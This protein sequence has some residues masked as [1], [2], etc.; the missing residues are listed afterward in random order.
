MAASSTSGVEYLS[1]FAR[2]HGD[3]SA[4]GRTSGGAAVIVGPSGE[5]ECGEDLLPAG[6]LRL[7]WSIAGDMVAVAN[8]HRLLVAQRDGQQVADIKLENVLKHLSWTLTQCLAIDRQNNI[9]HFDRELP[10]RSLGKVQQ[11]LEGRPTSLAGSDNGFYVTFAD[12][13]GFSWYSGD[14]WR[15]HPSTSDLDLFDARYSASGVY[16]AGMPSDSAPWSLP[17]LLRLR[18]WGPEDL[19]LAERQDFFDQQEVDGDLILLVDRAGSRCLY[20]NKRGVLT[21]PDFHVATFHARTREDI[22]FTAATAAEASTVYR[23]RD[24]ALERLIG[25]GQMH[26][27]AVG[28]ALRKRTLTISAY[29]VVRVVEP[30]VATRRQLQTVLVLH[31][32]PYAAL[33]L[34]YPSVWHEIRGLLA[35]GVRIALMDP[36]GSRGFGLKLGALPLHEWGQKD[37]EQVRSILPMLGPKEQ[38]G[39]LGLSYGGYLAA[40]LAEEAL[41]ARAVLSRGVTDLAA[42]IDR[43]DLLMRAAATRLIPLDQQLPPPAGPPVVPTLCLHGGLDER[44]PA[45]QIQRLGGSARLVLF[46]REGHDLATWQPSS[47]LKHAHQV[48]TFLTSGSEACP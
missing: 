25:S 17:Q 9:V 43:Q 36:Q 22:I 32:G 21:P 27:P 7:G 10:A 11:R 44:V 8:G 31:G 16:A 46:E 41:V 15:H 19:C 14:K 38:L 3:W 29:P 13:G 4:F 1:A 26:D 18:P 28:Y 33:S 6:A 48:I 47:R 30:C 34:A 2:P 35:K 20:S 24:G 40:R 42:L 39:V 45:T 37:L 12:P 5:T 23:L